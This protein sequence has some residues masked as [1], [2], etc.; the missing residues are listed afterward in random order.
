MSI[1]EE[2]GAFTSLAIL[3][4]RFRLQ[5]TLLTRLFNHGGTDGRI[6]NILFGIAKL[7]KSMFISEVFCIGIYTVTFKYGPYR[8]PKTWLL[9]FFETK[10]YE[11]RAI[12]SQILVQK[13]FTNSSKNYKRFIFSKYYINKRRGIPHEPD[14]FDPSSDDNIS[15]SSTYDISKSEQK[16]S[17]VQYNIQWE[18][19]ISYK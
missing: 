15:N 3:C 5:I 9:A 11:D 2:Y 13:C 12:I 7:Q 8:P 4:V 6:V 18:K 1:F 17:I 10:H 19:S 16:F 14:S